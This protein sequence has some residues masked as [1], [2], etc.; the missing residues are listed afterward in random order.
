MKKFSTLIKETYITDL[1]D[2]VNIV[3]EAD[4]LKGKPG[5]SQP[6]KSETNELDIHVE[7]NDE[8]EDDEDVK[9]F[10]KNIL[11]FTNERDS[12]KNKTL[13]NLEDAIKGKDIEIITFVS[14]EVHYKT[15]DTQILINDDKKK[16]KIDKQSN[17]DTI[18]IVRLGAQESEE[19]ME[20]IK[21]IQD[22]GIFVLNPIQSAKRASNKYQACVLMERYGIPQPKFTLVCKNDIEKNEESLNKKLKDIYKEVGKDDASN[23]I[24]N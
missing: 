12:K 7:E 16:Y 21:E 18:C 13:K 5:K 8:D 3:N 6:D 22:W 2:I 19:C 15:T 11:Y 1:N 24:C 10:F 14:D 4:E 17:I 20:C 23:G 9:Y